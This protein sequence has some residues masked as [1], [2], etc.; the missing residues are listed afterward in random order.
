VN[1]DDWLF[2]LG[3]KVPLVIAVWLSVFLVGF[4]IVKQ[5]TLGDCNAL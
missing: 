3:I 2:T 5:L 4:A 1:F